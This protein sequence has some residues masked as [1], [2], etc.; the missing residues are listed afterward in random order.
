MNPTSCDVKLV[1]RVRTVAGRAPRKRVLPD[2]VMGWLVG[3]A[4]ASGI[5][6]V[7]FSFGGTSAPTFNLDWEDYSCGSIH[8]GDPLPT[9]PLRNY[10][11]HKWTIIRW[12]RW[13][14]SWL[15]RPPAVRCCV[16]RPA[17]RSVH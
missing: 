14:S 2:E 8:L 4:A 3:P 15:S 13:R 7:P 9:A 17:V 5:P 10:R 11:S 1:L 12:T 16:S 6:G